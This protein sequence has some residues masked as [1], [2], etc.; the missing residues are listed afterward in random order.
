[1]YRIEIKAEEQTLAIDKQQRR[2]VNKSNK[3]K[4]IEAVASIR[5]VQSEHWQQYNEKDINV[6]A[7]WLTLH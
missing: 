1:M 2:K 7:T 4:D 3:R 5:D 6:C